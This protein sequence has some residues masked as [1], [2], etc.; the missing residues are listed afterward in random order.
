MRYLD[1]VVIKLRSTVAGDTGS[2]NLADAGMLLLAFQF[3][4]RP[5][6][7]AML[8]MQN[9]RIWHDTTLGP[10]TVHLT[11]HMAKQRGTATRMPL[12]RRVKREWAPIFVELYERRRNDGHGESARFF[13]VKSA[14]ETGC[15]I[16]ALTRALI[17]ST[18]RGSATDL[19]HTAAQR[20]VDAGASH[21]ELAEFMGHSSLLSGLVYYETSASH[22]E[23]LNRALGLSDLYRQ[24]AQIAHDRFISSDELRRLK[25]DQQ[26]GGVPHGIAIAG[27]GGCS[28]GQPAC[29]YNPVTSCYGCHKFMPLHDKAI[30]ERVLAAMREVVL[31][32]D[33]S[34]R[35]D[36]SSPAYLQ[37]QRTIEEIKK[38]IAELEGE[39]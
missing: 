4:M 2:H 24:V 23:R 35:G 14:C 6:Q 36:T 27:I 32:Y 10:P 26:I 38:V 22:A 33:Q 17:H 7:I 37:L 28:S 21:E 31:F 34:A 5:I 20:L 15:R 3:A 30:H 39:D 13:E 29:P 9:V 11:F 12:P 18:T 25:G 19:R 8:P 1:E 16:A